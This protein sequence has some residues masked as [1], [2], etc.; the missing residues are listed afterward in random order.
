[1][2]HLVPRVTDCSSMMMKLQQPSDLLEAYLELV[3]ALGAVEVLVHL[4]TAS[5]RLQEAM[6]EN[7]GEGR[8]KSKWREKQILTW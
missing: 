7:I 6:G 2:P 3:L 4:A 8:N 1:M 5:M